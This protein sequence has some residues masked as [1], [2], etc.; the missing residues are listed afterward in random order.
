MNNRVELIFDNTLT[1]LVGYEYGKKVYEQQVQ[2][3]I[4]LAKEFQLVFPKQIKGMA[5]SFVQGF[6]EQIVTT[7]GLLKTEK[8]TVIISEKEGFSE[9]V[10]SKLV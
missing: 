2:G 7:I 9:M 4:D 10:M 1:N 6:F 8:H 5:S 3:K